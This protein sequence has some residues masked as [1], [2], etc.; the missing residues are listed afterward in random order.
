MGIIIRDIFNHTEYNEKILLLEIHVPMNIQS[1]KKKYEINFTENS[2]HI[3][4]HC[5]TNK[6]IFSLIA[7]YEN[8]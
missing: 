6:S 3:R 7:Q 1:K 2:F 4:L 5:F 8:T